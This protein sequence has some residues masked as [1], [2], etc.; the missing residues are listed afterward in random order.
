MHPSHRWQSIHALHPIHPIHR[1]HSSMGRSRPAQPASAAAESAANRVDSIP[2]AGPTGTPTGMATTGSMC[3][4]TGLRPLHR[5]LQSAQPA[6]ST[7]SNGNLQLDAQQQQPAQAAT[8]TS[9]TVSSS[10]CQP[11][12]LPHCAFECT[13][14]GLA[15]DEMLTFLAMSRGRCSNG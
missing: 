5:L 6:A 12:L 1:T 3:C 11:L 14:L 9:S 7:S 15:L 10:V 13:C 4:S 2:F 8:N